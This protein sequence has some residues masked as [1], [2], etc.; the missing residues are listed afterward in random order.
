MREQAFLAELSGSN[1]LSDW[2][3]K[4]FPT[5]MRF[6]DS[7]KLTIACAVPAC[8]SPI[9]RHHRFTRNNI[10]STYLTSIILSVSACN[11][12]GSAT[13]YKS[14]SIATLEVRHRR[15]FICT[16]G[17]RDCLVHHPADCPSGDEG[18]HCNR[19]IHIDVKKCDF[20]TRQNNGVVSDC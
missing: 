17:C 4:A 1:G 14:T 15:P 10:F 7:Y 5:L 8:T 9:R 16:G 2:Y 18:T 13:R 19:G 3:V 12:F 20:I 6:T 11:L